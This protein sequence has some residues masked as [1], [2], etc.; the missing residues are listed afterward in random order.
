MYIYIYLYFSAF[1]FG[2]IA[3]GMSYLSPK[4][5]DNIFQVSMSIFGTAG[6]PLLGVFILAIFFPCVNSFVSM[7]EL[8]LV[9][10]NGLL[11][12]LYTCGYL[13]INNCQP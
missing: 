7:L 10:D 2:F 3:I 8:I 13:F 6:G 11:S 5:G 12:W 9:F 4:M 1:M